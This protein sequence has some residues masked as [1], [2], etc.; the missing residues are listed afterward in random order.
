MLSTPT[1]SPASGDSTLPRAETYDRRTIHLHWLT[2]VLVAATWVLAEVIDDFPRGMPRIGARSTHIILGVLLIVV[3][4]RRVW[5]RVWHGQRLA[6]PGPRW[7]TSIAAAA[8]LLLYAGL[9]VV[10]M[11]GV[12]NAWARGDTLFGLVAIPKL[13]PS[14]TQLK[15]TLESLHRFMANALVIAAAAHAL[16]ACLHHFY[17]KDEVLR[18]M[19]GR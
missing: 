16:A 3:V 4:A 1:A 18:R 8:H 7:L 19:L 17:L 9:V 14:H 11:V 2:A 15:P 13:L 10:L 12:A 6:V 5:W